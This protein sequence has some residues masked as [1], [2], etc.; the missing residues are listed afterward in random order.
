M[1][2][3]NDMWKS[4]LRLSHMWG[5]DSGPTSLKQRAITFLSTTVVDDL[6]KLK[7][8][9]D[10]EVT[11][12]RRPI[13]EKFITQ[14]AI[15]NPNQAPW[16]GSDFFFNL[17]QAREARYKAFLSR[18]IRGNS[19]YLRLCPAHEGTCTKLLMEDRKWSMEC[20]FLP[21]SLSEGAACSTTVE[22]F[23]APDL[24]AELTKLVDGFTLRSIN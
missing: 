19:S 12:W 14:D 17:S 10:F 23:M 2:L 20:A 24:T 9:Y 3:T 4:V 18:T 6:E 22:H 8:A 21:S 13:Y 15:I 1:S 11:S 7:L 5:F 16:L